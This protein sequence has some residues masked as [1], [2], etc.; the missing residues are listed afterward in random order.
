MG[1][2]RGSAVFLGVLVALGGGVLYGVQWA[3][4]QLDGD[5]TIV[6]GAPVEYEVVR[7]ASLA[8][9]A[10]DLE[11]AGVIENAFAFRTVARA[12]G[13]YNRLQAGTYELETGMSAGEV[14]AA[15]DLGVQ[16]VPEAEFR[17]EEG[18]TVR[19]TL[20]RL[21]QQF[22]DH[23]VADFQ[24]VLDARLEAG[25]NTE[26]T[27]RLPTDLLPEPADLPDTVRDPYEGLL[28]PETYRVVADASPQ[29]ILQRMVDQ[30]TAQLEAVTDEQRAALD[31]ND[32]TLYD[33]LTIASLVE[34]ETRVDDERAQVASVIE[35]R[36]DI[37]QALQIDATVLYALGEQKD[38]V[39]QVDTEVESP[40]NTYQVQGLPP[41]PI[42]GFGSASF[43][44]AL[45]PA[46]TPFT[47]YVL[48]PACD[49]THVFAETLDEHNRNVAAFRAAG[50]CLDE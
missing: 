38:R 8:S 4:D 2:S 1:L 9:I 21:A 31:A 5:E 14:I 16:G 27:V 30:L 47:Y 25:E 23:D 28:W 33:A 22:E 50:N 24:A 48:T 6:A 13:F 44:A 49:G 43:Q 37:G 39:L 11:E 10:G 12:D 18:L 29:R 45:S 15:F 36:L 19:Q 41:T 42:S 17:V 3:N 35:N 46:D 32:L 34:R 40:Y 26:D 20:R 7:G